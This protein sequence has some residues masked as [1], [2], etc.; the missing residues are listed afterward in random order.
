MTTT[1]DGAQRRAAKV[2]G[3]AFPLSFAIVVAVNFGIFE[4]L[5][6]HL[7]PA[8][9]AH[10]IVAHETLFRLGVTGFVLYGVGVLVVSAALYVLLSPVSRTLALLATFGRAIHGL[11]WLLVA[12]NQFAALRLLTRPE[13]AGLPADQLPILARLF[14]SGFDQYYVGLLFWSLGATAGAWAWMRS[15][16]IPRVMGAFGVLASAWCAGCTLVLFIFPAFPRIVNLWWF[17]VPMVLFELAVSALLLFRGL[18]APE[19][20]AGA[21]PTRA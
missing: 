7:E 9:V 10:N 14:L 5:T 17:D 15:G 3:L 18:Q 19:Q 16:H 4:R 8:E 1:I 12:L 11:S 21:Q 2:V 13:F 20:H 6:G